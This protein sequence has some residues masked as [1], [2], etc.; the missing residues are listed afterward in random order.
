MNTLTFDTYIEKVNEVRKSCLRPLTNIFLSAS[1]AADL[2][3][4]KSCEFY[5]HKDTFLA[6]V[7]Y[8]DKYFD[9]LYCAASSDKLANTLAT[10]IKSY[11]KR[12]SLRIAVIGLSQI[13]NDISTKLENIHI[14]LAKK[15]ARVSFTNTKKK[16]AKEFFSEFAVEK[17]FYAS[18]GIQVEYAREEDSKEILTLLL[19]EFDVYTENIPELST[20]IENINDKHVVIA[21]FNNHII[22][23]NYFNINNNIRHCIYE[24]VV[25]E[26]R[27]I[28]LMLYINNFVEIN[29]INKITI[30]RTYGWR[31]MGNKRLIKAYKALGEKF[32]GVYIYNHL[33]DKRSLTN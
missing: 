9:V 22:A 15:I 8:H 18:K 12:F 3:E 26:F 17:E 16:F 7:P 24:F 20:I 2:L 4:Q 25:P 29:L 10:F 14:P 33:Y 1:G 5:T 21:R 13:V 30:T 31:D 11:D 28:Q 19:S 6:F 27:K 23:I 32:E